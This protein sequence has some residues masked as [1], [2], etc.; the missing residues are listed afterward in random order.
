VGYFGYDLAREGG[1]VLEVVEEWAGIELH[2][3]TTTQSKGCSGS[4]MNGK[5]MRK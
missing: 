2:A 1:L 4:R 5:F 3:G